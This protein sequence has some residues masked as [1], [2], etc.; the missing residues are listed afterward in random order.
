M[1]SS[2]GEGGPQ[3]LSKGW[4]FAG[5][6]SLACVG[7]SALAQDSKDIALK[8]LGK[9]VF[10]DKSLS[11]SGEMGCVSC[12]E[13]ATGGT[14]GD[15]L[16]NEGQ[17]AITGADPSTVGRRRPNTNTYSSFVEPF[18][19]CNRGGPSTPPGEIQYCGGNFWDGRA[20]G[21]ENIEPL[22][23]AAPHIGM[24]VFWD[25]ENPVVLGYQKYISAITD[26]AINPI[27]SLVEQNLPRDQVCLTVQASNYAWLYELAWDTPLNCSNVI[28][29]NGERHLDIAFKRLMM[30]VGAYQHSYDINSFT[31]KRDLAIRSELACV[32][33][34]FGEYLN[35]SVCDQVEQLRLT[36][37]SKQYGKFPLVLFTAEE[38]LGHDLFYNE[39]FPPIP[40][41]VPPRADLPVTNCSFCHSDDPDND[42]GAELFQTYSDQAFHNIGVPPNPDIP[43]PT[44]LDDLGLTETTG[45]HRPGF[46]RTQTV[47][48]VDKRP[49]PEFVKAYMHN[50]FFKSLKSV[51]HFY[52]TR[53]TKPSCN[54]MLTNG[55][56]PAGTELTE[57]VALAYDCWP[58]PEFDAF[59]TPS[60]LAG[61]LGMTPEQE[62]ALVVYMQT[63]TDL[64]SADVPELL[65]A[66][67]SRQAQTFMDLRLYETICSLGEENGSNSEQRSIGGGPRSRASCMTIKEAAGR[68][69]ENKWVGKE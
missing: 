43:K 44:G 25:S 37:P 35:P 34:N 3:R 12:H 65:K 67:P 26:Q 39:A 55:D 8:L 20:L 61:G 28:A 9:H 10:F 19:P 33:S 59:K 1:V 2:N 15:S 31:S 4:I 45:V 21:R 62:D 36:D 27:P 16:V 52:N 22:S 5:I 18:L 48:N 17:V 51:V 46:T 41:N 32:D 13:P 23:G 56:I 49:S 11:S 53:D 66:R 50:G 30:A 14:G 63:L 40:G 7:Q 57:A 60:I 47:R 54:V 6:I 24:E 69:H 29:Y 68:L 64:H 58:E 42:D 38:N